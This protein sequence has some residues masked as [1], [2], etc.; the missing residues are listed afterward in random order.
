MIDNEF[1]S[2]N[3]PL[4]DKYKKFFDKFKEIETTP[5]VDWKPV[6]LI[7][8][9]AK[10]YFD[11][12]QVKYQFKFNTPSP[13]KSFEIFQIKRLALRLTSDPTILRQYID[14]AFKT[15][16][17]TSK[18]R[19]TSISFMTSE[20]LLNNYKFNVLLPSN[21]TTLT[22]LERGTSL[23]PNIKSHF[24]NINYINT[25]GDLAFIHKSMDKNAEDMSPELTMALSN[26][27]NSGF[28]FNIL[29]R[30]T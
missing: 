8:Y 14:W 10:K 21:E 13:A 30:I 11:F 6:H 3:E 15:K 24:C 20:E 29:S 12:Y 19:L 7:A 26:L 18:R 27:K 28:D 17:E 22:K 1:G 4:N 9:F 25:Y 23:P 2:F 16:A 5:T